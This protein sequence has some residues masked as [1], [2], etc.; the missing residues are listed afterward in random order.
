VAWPACE[1]AERWTATDLSRTRGYTRSGWTRLEAAL[2]LPNKGMKLTS[3]ERIGRSQLIPGVGRTK[4][5]G[6]DG[7]RILAICVCTVVLCAGSREGNGFTCNAPPEYRTSEIRI[8][9]WHC[10]GA[11][12]APL[13]RAEMRLE[14]RYLGKR[15]WSGF[16]DGQGYVEI[17]GAPP[18]AYLLR[19]WLP[20]FL[21]LVTPVRVFRSGE[22]PA[23][24][25][26]VELRP[27]CPSSCQVPAQGPR[28]TRPECLN[29]DVAR[30]PTRG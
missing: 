7:S 11:E 17:T 25:L 13:K 4:R 26:A 6:M 29:G 18:G 27:G 15:A 5:A 24:L 14:D 21:E 16:T 10:L 22:W 3:V 1:V 20:G 23:R 9:V 30:R 28:S 8:Q 12:C 2:G 19:V